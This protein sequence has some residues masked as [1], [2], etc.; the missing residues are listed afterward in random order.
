MD[1][2][3]F[4]NYEDEE[5]EEDEEIPYTTSQEI[6]EL[7]ADKNQVKKYFQAYQK[8]GGISNYNLFVKNLRNFF[9]ITFDMFVNGLI[10]PKYGLSREECIMK[11][12]THM[13]DEKE[14]IRYFESVDS[15]A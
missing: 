3:D 8:I 7:I 9:E 15:V 10:N 2:V 5:D 6:D 11:W 14:A 12:I 1:P 13:K 4:S